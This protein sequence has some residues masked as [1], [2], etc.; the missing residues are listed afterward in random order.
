[1]ICRVAASSRI[2]RRAIGLRLNPLLRSLPL[3]GDAGL[4]EQSLGCNQPQ[5]EPLHQP[6]PPQLAEPLRHPRFG[7]PVVGQNARSFGQ[8]Q[9]RELQ[10]IAAARQQAH[11]LKRRNR[12][13]GKDRQTRLLAVRRGLGKAELQP[14]ALAHRELAA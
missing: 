1:M 6:C 12:L 5:L 11:R 2:R 7:H 14:V 13:S 8:R 4:F 10:T 9:K 3:F